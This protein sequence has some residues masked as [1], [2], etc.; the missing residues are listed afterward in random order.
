MNGVEWSWGSRVWRCRHR[1]MGDDDGFC[2]MGLGCTILGSMRPIS[3]VTYQSYGRLLEVAEWFGRP[4]DASTS[5][6][7]PIL[8]HRHPRRSPLLSLIHS[9]PKILVTPSHP[10]P[11]PVPNPIHP[12]YLTAQ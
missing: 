8:L 1:E 7:H 11:A 5:G 4:N 2:R 3:S 10:R 6:K 12:S 9:Q